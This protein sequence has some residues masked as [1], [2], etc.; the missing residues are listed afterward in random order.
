ML[1][2]S[3]QARR[4]AFF[5]CLQRLYSTV[6]GLLDKASP[7][8]NF[9]NSLILERITDKNILY[10]IDF[11]NINQRSDGVSFKTKQT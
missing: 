8:R 2:E 9:F 5:Y 4:L 3:K 7:V 11:F 10:L 1:P 6:Q